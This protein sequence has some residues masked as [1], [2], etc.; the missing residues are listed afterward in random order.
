MSTISFANLLFGWI[1][2]CPRKFV[3]SIRGLF[4][5]VMLPIT[6]KLSYRSHRY[7]C[8]THY[9][10]HQAIIHYCTLHRGYFQYS[11]LQHY[12]IHYFIHY[13]ATFQYCTLHQAYLHYHTLY[14]ATFS[15][16]TRPMMFYT[17]VLLATLLFHILL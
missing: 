8:F 12:I 11:S 14:H 1:I 10:L 15:F 7:R 2:V 3:A 4:S 9:T 5:Y 13:H 16:C 6:V 17:I